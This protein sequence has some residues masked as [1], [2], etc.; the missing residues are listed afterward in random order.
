MEGG[1]DMGVANAAGIVNTGFDG[2]GGVEDPIPEP[3]GRDNRYYS[4]RVTIVPNTNVTGN[5]IITVK[6]FRDK[7]LPVAKE[8]LP[9]PRQEIASTQLNQMVR[10]T[11]LK[12]GREILT[13]PIQTGEHQDRADLMAAWKERRDQDDDPRS[14]LYDQSPF[15][16]EVVGGN[17]TDLGGFDKFIIPAGGYLVLASGAAATSGIAS[18]PRSINRKL[19]TEQENYNVVYGFGLPSPSERSRGFLPQRGY[20]E[21]AV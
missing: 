19:T 5:V 14:G 17:H 18:S 8:Y 13:V 7:T 6:R 2:T 20:L 11:R 3:T 4:Y 1:Y 21:S 12:N 15:V 16:R 9:I 10:N